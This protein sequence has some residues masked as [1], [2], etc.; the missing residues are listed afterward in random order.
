MAQRIEKLSNEQVQKIGD[1]QNKITETLL[2][3]GEGHLRL[4][5]LNLEIER[6]KQ[7]VK[8]SE[9]EFDSHNKQYNELLSDLE[10]KYPNGEIDLAQG[11]IIINE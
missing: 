3:L 4:R 5:E 9:V 7:I 11:N 8:N 2:S 6:V 1:L 10:N